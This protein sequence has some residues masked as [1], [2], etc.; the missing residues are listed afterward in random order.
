[1]EDDYEMASNLK[2]ALVRNMLL[3]IIALVLVYGFWNHTQ[4]YQIG[5][6]PLLIIGSFTTYIIIRLT[7]WI[8]ATDF[9]SRVLDGSIKFS[10][11]DVD[12]VKYEEKVVI[13]RP[14]K[15][16]KIRIGKHYLAKLNPKS[17]K[18]FAKLYVK[19][20]YRK[21][22]GDVDEI[23]AK[24]FGAQSLEEF[25]QLWNKK[26]KTWDPN[27]MVRVVEFKVISKEEK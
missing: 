11:E 10:K 2:N 9:F 24:K 12:P 23:E 27:K 5:F 19:D 21:S 17:K 4:F 26:Y 13:I 20:N 25:K 15:V 14:W 1:M 16:R 8:N 22:L 3:F 7:V 18:Y 6:L